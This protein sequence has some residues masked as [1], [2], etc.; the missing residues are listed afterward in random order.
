MLLNAHRQRVL[1][2]C[3]I[4]LIVSGGE[5]AAVGPRPTHTGTHS[6]DISIRRRRH[7]FLICVVLWLW[8]GIRRAP[9]VQVE[10]IQ[11]EWAQLTGYHFNAPNKF[12]W[13]AADCILMCVRS[14]PGTQ[15]AAYI[16]ELHFSCIHIACIY[17]G[18]NVHPVGLRANAQAVGYPFRWCEF[19]WAHSQLRIYSYRAMY[20]ML[21]GGVAR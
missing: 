13:G 16:K 18:L 8:A 17:S 15:P 6:I 2:I 5:Q 21:V 10:V 12:G 19:S 11:L 20:R 4:V 1:L 9:S 3:S 7:S 14:R